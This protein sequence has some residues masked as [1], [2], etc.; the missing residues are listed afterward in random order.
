[1]G[2]TDTFDSSKWNNVLE[3]PL[4]HAPNLTMYVLYGTGKL[5]ERAAFLVD[6]TLPPLLDTDLYHPSLNIS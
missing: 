1:M 5:T 6:R 3:S 2:V 4:P